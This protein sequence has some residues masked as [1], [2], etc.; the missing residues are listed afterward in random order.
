MTLPYEPREDDFEANRIP[1]VAQVSPPSLTFWQDAWQRLT[2]NRLALTSLWIVVAML[3]FTVFGPELWRVDPN[4]QSLTEISLAPTLGRRALLV[5]A[6]AKQEMT[7]TALPFAAL[8]TS[9]TESVQLVWQAAP[10]ATQYRLFRHEYPPS[11]EH[12]L[13]LPLATLEAAQHSYL[14]R[15]RLESRRYYYTLVIERGSA[16]P[17][18]RRLEITPQQAITRHEALR[19]GLL[20]DENDA[21]LWVRLPAHPFG[22]D[23]LGRDMLA[24]VMQGA[25]TS[26]FIGVV[27]PL[28]FILIGVV[29][30]AVAGFLGGHV[31]REM[32][33]VAD[34]VMALPFVLFMVLFKIMF[35]IGAG[36]SGVLP[37]LVA[38][39]ALSW[40]VSARLVRAQVLQSRGLA[41]VSAA[42]LLGAG[43]IYIVARHLLPNLLSSVL[44]S[45]T[46]A[47]PTAIFTEAFLSFIGMGVVPPTPSWGSLCNE[48][49]HSVLAHPHELIFPALFISITVLA[50][51]M[52][53]DGLR[54]CLDVRLR[55]AR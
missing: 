17:T 34:F 16:A 37:M 4:A 48:G 7:T 11:G 29:Y 13:G 24:R 22:T 8:G 20:T 46:F 47:I 53:G 5:S 15:L 52:L 41:F 39:V 36:E 12:D 32:M 14:D 25:R 38:L 19:L 30:G 43:P 42:R 9:T 44:V 49:L 50:F 18:Y 31:D 40:P 21:R 23:A 1:R 28:A 27:A 33:R 6:P 3:C 55:V 2:G 26:L 10:T 45:L 35:G 54:D 51:N